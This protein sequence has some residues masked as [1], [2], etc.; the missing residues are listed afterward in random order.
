MIYVFADCQL[1][2][3]LYALYRAGRLWRLRPKVYRV[4][5]YLLLH[6]DR[7]VS[8]QELC[9]QIWGARAISDGAIENTMQAIRRATGDN[10][11]KQQ[12]IQTSYGH[13][14][15]FVAPVT[16][17]PTTETDTAPID[18]RR[19]LPS[20]SRPQAMRPH[21]T[22]GN[23]QPHQHIAR[24]LTTQ[25]PDMVATHPALLAYHYTA[26]GHLHQAILCWQQAGQQ[27]L[28]R[29]AYPE[30]VASFTQG[31][32]LLHTLPNTPEQTRQE[33]VLQ[34]RLALP[35]S[36]LGSALPEVEQIYT[37]ALDLSH[38]VGT[39]QDVAFVLLGLARLYDRRGAFGTARAFAEQL[40][41][42]S[43]HLRAPALLLWSHNTLGHILMRLG[44]FTSARQHLEAGL[45]YYDAQQHCLYT[46]Q[47][48][49][50]PGLDGLGALSWTLWYLGYPEQALQRSR[51]AM[52][53][54]QTFAHPYSL[55]I[56]L[57]YAAALHALRQEW[58]LVQERAE[59]LRQLATTY[60]F[61]KLLASATRYQGM[62]LFWQNPSAGLARL[63]QGMAALQTLQAREARAAQLAGLAH[64]YAHV[65]H[66]QAGVRLVQEAMTVAHHTGERCAEARRYCTMGELLQR[67]TP[68]DGRQAESCLQQAL[69]IAQRQHAR[70]WELQAA[71]SL[72]R[73]WQ[74]QGK[75][76]AARELLAAV[77][78]RFTEGFTTL[79]L[80]QA[81]I[82]LEQLA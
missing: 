45:S 46:G 2:T 7:V 82:L 35:L 52:Q 79:D 80:Q 34:C 36:V 69:T 41:S 10:G 67:Q 29:S 68:T 28:E 16:V 70:A 48:G 53:L 37:R 59:A 49:V 18:D 13:G 47:Y 3:C 14:Y 25:F 6:R 11:R 72:S 54:A 64:M 4:L 20:A 24:L 33:L 39:P 81:R 44:E 26:A 50:D 56:T 9:E 62:A 61:A 30:A 55:G 38:Q 21:K 8:K 1:D 27:A 51:E 43:Q 17:A 15:R 65:G 19:A 73:L 40:L 57:T 77:Y 22:P 78:A 63:E 75:R 23:T 74:Q 31:L 12:I 5:T 66:I 42:V 60:G 71:M 32:A 58:H 76:F